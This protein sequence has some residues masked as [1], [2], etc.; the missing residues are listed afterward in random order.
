MTGFV[1]AI[2]D[3]E[4]RVKIGW[5]SDPVR[6]LTK[7]GS[8]CPQSAVL[9]GVV[10]ATKAQEKQTHEILQRWRIK[11][12]WF[13]LESHVATF[14]SMLPK[15]GPRLVPSVRTS[16][17]RHPLSIWIEANKL[18]RSQFAQDVG[19]LESHLC[20]L[21]AGRR[22]PSVE[23]LARIVCRTRGDIGIA[24]FGCAA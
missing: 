9:L 24:D 11:G 16:K 15:P 19:C 6:R 12:D 21:V 4:G 20:N 2:G 23:L 8:D 13:R 10:P 1:Y 17:H 18:T 22:R 14:V 5:S 3:G 7:L